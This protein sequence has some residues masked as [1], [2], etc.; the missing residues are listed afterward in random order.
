MRFTISYSH[1]NRS[2]KNIQENLKQ[3]EGSR[4]NQ[5]IGGQRAAA[6]NWLNILLYNFLCVSTELRAAFLLFALL[7][8]LFATLHFCL[9]WKL[10]SSTAVM[11]LEFLLKCTRQNNSVYIVCKCC[12]DAL[13]FKLVCLCVNMMSLSFFTFFLYWVVGTPRIKKQVLDLY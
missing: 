2:T 7:L 9:R 12:Y 8:A 6:A 1:Y 11:S 10:S 5:S 13:S 3:A 4:S